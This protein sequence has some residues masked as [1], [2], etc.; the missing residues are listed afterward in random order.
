M[1]VVRC[2]VWQ[3]SVVSIYSFVLTALNWSCRWMWCWM[4]MTLWI[5]FSSSKGYFFLVPESLSSSPEKTEGKP[6]YPNLPPSA[7]ANP[8]NLT[9]NNQSIGT[10]FT[11]YSP[12]GCRCRMKAVAS[13]CPIPGRTWGTGWRR[14]SRRVAIEIPSSVCLH[15]VC[16]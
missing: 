13:A 12:V 7:P 14:G 1:D 15:F 8:R 6:L 5:A 4:N 11:E 9:T 3:K 2:V 10:F 16:H